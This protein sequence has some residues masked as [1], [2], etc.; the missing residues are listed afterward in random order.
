MGTQWWKNVW[1]NDHEPV[2]FSNP[3]TSGI[4]LMAISRRSPIKAA[5]NMVVFL[6]MSLKIR[7]FRHFF[8]L[9]IL[10]IKSQ[11]LR[12]STYVEQVTL[13]VIW[14]VHMATLNN[15]NY[16]LKILPA[17][18]FQHFFQASQRFLPKV[19]MPTA[20]DCYVHRPLWVQCSWSNLQPRM[21]AGTVIN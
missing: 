10:A 21:P 12:V 18:I 13:P 2:D 6:R 14:Q 16:P 8:N 11:Q 7:L 17:S 19:P 3:F 9:Q 15:C 20:T 5:E 4:P 1:K